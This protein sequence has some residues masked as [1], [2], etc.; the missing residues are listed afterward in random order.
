MTNKNQITNLESHPLL[1]QQA[2]LLYTMGIKKFPKDCALKI[3]Y[4]QFLLYR[5]HNKKDALKELMIAEKSSPS[6][7]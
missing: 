5:M 6:F 4:A 3:E 1:L 7:E 2:K